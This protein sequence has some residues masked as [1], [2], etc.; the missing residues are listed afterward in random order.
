VFQRATDTACFAAPAR[1]K[2][3]ELDGS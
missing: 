1:L 3:L 2:I